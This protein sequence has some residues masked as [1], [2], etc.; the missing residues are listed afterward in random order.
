VPGEPQKPDSAGDSH[1]IGTRNDFAQ[2]KCFF[3]QFLQCGKVLLVCENF[4]QG[5]HRVHVSVVVGS[6]SGYGQSLPDGRFGFGYISPDALDLGQL[7]AQSDALSRATAALI[8]LFHGGRKMLF[9]LGVA[10]RLQVPL[11]LHPMP[12]AVQR[13]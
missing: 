5:I 6:L 13:P 10:P 7:Q 2:T 4:S 3:L 12:I 9:G 1:R 8:R 11:G